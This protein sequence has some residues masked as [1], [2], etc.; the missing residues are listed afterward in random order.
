MMDRSKGML[1]FWHS[2]LLK[3]LVDSESLSA[4][5]MTLTFLGKHL[6]SQ[7]AIFPSFPLVLST[8]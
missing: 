3:Y 7:K 4:V 6:G 5:T 1:T 2:N 8:K